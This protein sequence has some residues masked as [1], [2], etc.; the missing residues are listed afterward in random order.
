MTE[1]PPTARPR[2]QRRALRLPAPGAPHAEGL[3]REPPALP[4]GAAR[5][6]LRREARARA[7]REV[8]RLPRRREACAALLDRDRAAHEE[9]AERARPR[10]DR[11]GPRRDVA[12]EAARP[13]ASR[14]REPPRA[15]AGAGGRSA[16]GARGSRPGADPRRADAPRAHVRRLREALHLAAR[17]RPTPSRV[18]ARRAAHGVPTCPKCGGSFAHT[19]ALKIHPALLR[20]AARA[21]AR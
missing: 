19:G 20:A 9:Q 7:L 10:A 12:R 14:D 13:R 18:Q 11:A 8:R 1:R 6:R 3:R 4:R 16:G 5:D 17:L 15:R 2:A 21:G